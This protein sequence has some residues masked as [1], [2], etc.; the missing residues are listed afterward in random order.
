[1]KPALLLLAATALLGAAG[2]ALSG[3]KQTEQGAVQLPGERHAPNANL[4]VPP[5]EWAAPARA[6][7]TAERN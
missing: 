1:M 7:Q 6:P 5:D 2:C 3:Q 4:N